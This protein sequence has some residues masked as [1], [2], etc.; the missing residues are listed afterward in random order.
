MLAELSYVLNTFI[1]VFVIVD[2]FAVIPVYLALT[3]RFS[4]GVI[5]QIRIKATL[6]ALG[7][8]SVFAVS[9][10]SIFNLFGITLPAFQIAGGILLLG[11]GMAQLNANRPRVKQ[12]EAD[13]SLE[14]D[15]VSVFPLGTPL[16]AGPGAI[17]TVVL[18][19]TQSHN[20]FRSGGLLLAIVLAMVVTFWILKAA[21]Y[22]FR[23]LGKTGLNIL[24]RLMG[25]ILTA[26]AVQF[27]LNGLR[28]ALEAYGML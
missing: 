2:P 26:V 7:I 25:L 5:A 23:V 1:A 18:Y 9:G 8:L 20:W 16:L 6:V 15:D 12:E 4:P 13:E 27:F 11:I 21:P 28:G 19:S 24:T 22:L 10:L 14:R 17:S 3:D